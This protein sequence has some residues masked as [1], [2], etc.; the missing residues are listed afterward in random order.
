VVVWIVQDE[1][2]GLHRTGVISAFLPV[3]RTIWL[4]LDGSCPLFPQP[5]SWVLGAWQL[6]LKLL[7]F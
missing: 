1:Q 7:K 5:V 3:A 4:S 2:G 6:L